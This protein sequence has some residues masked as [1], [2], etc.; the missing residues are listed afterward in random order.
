MPPEDGQHTG[1]EPLS[2]SGDRIPQTLLPE[3]DPRKGYVQ[4]GRRI[5]TIE[6]FANLI[7]VGHKNGVTRSFLCAVTG[8]NDRTVRQMIHEARR[9]IIILNLQDG[10]GYYVPDMEDE[11]DRMELKR[12]V[13]QEESRLK[14]IGWSLAAARKTLSE[15]T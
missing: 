10:S 1:Q 8:M 14:S 3:L 5:M 11:T 7:P 15:I 12:Y 13:K 4:K 9:I 6:E 2:E